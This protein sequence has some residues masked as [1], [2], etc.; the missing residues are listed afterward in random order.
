MSVRAVASRAIQSS[1]AGP[2][3]SA[4]KGLVNAVSSIFG[5]GPPAWKRSQAFRDYEAARDLAQRGDAAALE[6]LAQLAGLRQPDYPGTKHSVVRDRARNTYMNLSQGR[7]A[8]PSSG[9]AQVV[10]NGSLPRGV[11]RAQSAPAAPAAPRPKPPCKYGP[12]VDGYCPK[13]PPAG[14]SGG[15]RTSGRAKPPCKYGPRGEDGYCPKKGQGSVS[16]GGV[17][18]KLPASVTRK[19]EASVTK[20]LAP[21][22]TKALPYIAKASLVGLAGYAAYWL[23]SKLQRYRYKTYDDLRY[24]AANAYR[25]ARQQAAA[26][27]GRGLTPAENKQLA[28]Y[29]KQSMAQLDQW[30]RDK[31]PI[32]Q[33]TFGD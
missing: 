15:R 27:N 2:A 7:G 25:E 33:L 21:A 17:T 10:A 19:I 22:V 14:A 11:T 28:D 16:V 6:R 12:R 1:P 3:Y 24:A 32:H 30:E 20:S 23:T 4:A 5:G 18:A 29:F 31:R 8:W 9:V 13:K 26:D